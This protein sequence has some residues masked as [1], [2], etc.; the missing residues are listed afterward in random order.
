MYIFM[1]Y[2]MIASIYLFIYLSI[3]FS[4]NL[5]NYLFIYPSRCDGQLL[6]DPL[7]LLNPGEMGRETR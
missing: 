3:Y 5:Y 6:L 4:I 7:D 2:Y 1:Y